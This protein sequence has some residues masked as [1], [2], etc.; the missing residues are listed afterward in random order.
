LWKHPVHYRADRR[1]AAAYFKFPQLCDLA[2]HVSEI[3]AGLTKGN[4]AIPV[5]P[6]S[7]FYKATA[8]Q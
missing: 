7:T 4:I 8:T 2:V 3:A 5:K 6:L 1:N